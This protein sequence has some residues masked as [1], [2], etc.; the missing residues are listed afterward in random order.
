MTEFFN[1]IIKVFLIASGVYILYLVYLK[2]S[3][4][5]TTEDILKDNQ[6]LLEKYKNIK[7]QHIIVFIIG[8]IIG[9]GVLVLGDNDKI[10]ETLSN[11]NVVKDISDIN[12][13]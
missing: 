13:I 5:E 6:E 9:L 12:V 7:K 1:S 3:K 11:E 2:L 8:I 10:K 4:A